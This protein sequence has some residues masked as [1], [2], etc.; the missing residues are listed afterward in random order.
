MV[1]FS[2]SAIINKVIICV[3]IFAFASQRNHTGRHLKVQITTNHAHCVNKACAS[4][5]V[6]K[7][8]K[9]K[10]INNKKHHH[11]QVSALHR[12]VEAHIL[13]IPLG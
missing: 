5:A 6:C 7:K 9:N 12:T 3:L 8:N 13:E 11:H 10:N 4:G 2:T 1:C